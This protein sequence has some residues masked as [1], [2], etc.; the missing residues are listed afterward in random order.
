MLVPLSLLVEELLA[1][2]LTPLLLGQNKHWNG[3]KSEFPLSW[4]LSER[5]L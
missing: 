5:Q 4:V 3:Q 2:P 1:Q